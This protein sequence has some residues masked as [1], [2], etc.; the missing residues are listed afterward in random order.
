MQRIAAEVDDDACKSRRRHV[1][2]L[3][4]GVADCFL[5]RYQADSLID[6]FSIVKGIIDTV[7]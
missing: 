7:G 5:A 6:D 2:G 1:S 4:L 3:K